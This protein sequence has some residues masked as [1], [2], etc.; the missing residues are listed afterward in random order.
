MKFQ[1]RVLKRIFGLRERNNRKT[2]KIA[3]RGAS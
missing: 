2:E 3:Q 1:D